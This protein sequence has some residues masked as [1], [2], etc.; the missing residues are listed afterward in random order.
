MN[1]R[2][3]ASTSLIRSATA[4]DQRESSLV[5]R[6]FHPKKA[7]QAYFPLKKVKGHQQG[8]TRKYPDSGIIIIIIILSNPLPVPVSFLLRDFKGKYSLSLVLK[9]SPY[10]LF[11]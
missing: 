7:G 2:V 9:N 11:V 10:N 1:S 6:S 8:T 4:I 5:K 3:L